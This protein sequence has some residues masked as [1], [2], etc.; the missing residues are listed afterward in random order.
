MEVQM[1]QR[2]GTEFL[3]MEKIAPTDIHQH[4]LNVSVD[5]TVDVSTERLWV[6]HFSSGSSGSPQLLQTFTSVACRLLLITSKYTS[7]V[8]AAVLK[9]GVL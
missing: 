2:C 3:H 1:K 7:P 8:M 6:V 9:N 4:L 5:Q